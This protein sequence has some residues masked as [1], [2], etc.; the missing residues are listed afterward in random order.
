LLDRT[1][2][3]TALTRGMEQVVLIGDRDAF[4]AAVTAP[5]HSRERQVLVLYRKR[6][7][8]HTV[9]ERRGLPRRFAFDTAT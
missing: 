9:G 8:A 1:L 2:I 4:D 6:T 3:Y 5:P 7:G